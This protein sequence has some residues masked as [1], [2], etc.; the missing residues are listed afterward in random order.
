MNQRINQ[1]H[2]LLRNRKNDSIQTIPIETKPIIKCDIGDIRHIVQQSPWRVRWD[3]SDWRKGG[4]FQPLTQKDWNQTLISKINQISAQI[5]KSTLRGGANQ[6]IINPAV[7]GLFEDLE[8]YDK[9][10]MTIGG[11]YK[12]LLDERLAVCN[13]LLVYASNTTV[14]LRYEGYVTKL[15]NDEYSHLFEN[16]RG[17]GLI[18]LDNIPH[19]NVNAETELTAILSEQF[20]SGIDKEIVNALTS[21]LKKERRLLLMN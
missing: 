1:N 6:I 8:Y 9:K 18:I 10:E 15:H 4:G 13:V 7:L 3:Y 21:N 5:H 16:N 20:A 11:R 19:I 14:E 12:V 2:I 17:S